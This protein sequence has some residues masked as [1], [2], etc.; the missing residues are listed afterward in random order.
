GGVGAAGYLYSAM[1][2]GSLGVTLFS[3]WTR[4]VERRGAVVVIAAACWGLAIIGLGYAPSLP[5]AF[6][7]LVLAGGADMVSGLFRMTIWNET[8]PSELRGRMAGIEQLSYMTGPLLG[9]ARAGFMAERMGLG[10]SIRWGGLIC[11]ACVVACVPILPA[12]WR[13]QRD[14][15]VIGT[16][17]A[18]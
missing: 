18:A 11:A 16:E 14:V 4:N 5:V 9:N 7:C 8:I 17:P 2:V 10:R 6:V 15:K 3:G 13:Y 1:S 12:F